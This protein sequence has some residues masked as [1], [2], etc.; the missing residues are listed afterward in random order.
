MASHRGPHP[1][2]EELFAP[3]QIPRLRSAVHDL[4]WLRTRG[5]GDTSALELVGNRYRLRR[6]QRNAVA[7]SACTDEQWAHRR[8]RRR[9][10]HAFR[11]QWIEIDGF[12]V[13]ISVEGMLGGAYLFIG[14]DGAVRDVKAV[15]RTYRIVEETCP[16]IC[17]VREAAKES[18][19]R[20]LIW[21]L[22]DSVSNAGRLKE[23]LASCAPTALGWR[24]HI[25]DD[26]DAT[27]RESTRPVA[28]SDSGILDHTD[29]WCSIERAVC[30]RPSNGGTVRD[31]RPQDPPFSGSLYSRT[32][33]NP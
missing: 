29:I 8:V 5:Y 14:R 25:Q 9:G 6:R 18:G 16:A 26:V 12:N 1:K 15:Q 3:S 24:I 28:T 22:D 31:L 10:L 27:L 7:R 19:V 20:G 32:F 11:G 13:L 33:D 2:D 23:T 4:S 17:D 30:F 21:R